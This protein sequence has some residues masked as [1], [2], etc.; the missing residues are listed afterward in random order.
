[1]RRAK[2]SVGSASSFEKEAI[3]EKRKLLDLA[4]F[5]NKLYAI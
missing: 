1:M 4:E 5:T 2:G 3:E